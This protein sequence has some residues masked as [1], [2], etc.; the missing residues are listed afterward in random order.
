MI[1]QTLIL[2]LAQ[3]AVLTPPADWSTAQL[4]PPHGKTVAVGAWAMP[5]KGF[6]QNI[7]IHQIP[8]GDES[9]ES[10]AAKKAAAVK[11]IGEVVANH[12]EKLCDGK[13]NGWYMEYTVQLGARPA[14]IEQVFA[15]GDNSVFTATYSRGQDQA[16][17]PAARKALGSLCVE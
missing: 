1:L 7:V 5:S 11:Q 12:A 9:L 15:S 14:H 13:L 16:E 3:T 8:K 6:V 4:P 17:D 2:A 10:V